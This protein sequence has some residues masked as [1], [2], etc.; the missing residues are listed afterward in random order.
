M[1]QMALESE[2]DG[3][4]LVDRRRKIN[5]VFEWLEQDASSDPGTDKE[6]GHR[7]QDTATFAQDPAE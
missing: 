6:D 7:G 4:K 1:P 2:L 5:V 3:S